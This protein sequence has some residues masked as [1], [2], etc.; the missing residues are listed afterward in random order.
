MSAAEVHDPSRTASLGKRHLPALF[1]PVLALVVLASAVGRVPEALFNADALFAPA[2]YRDLFL[3]GG[4]I[5]A[6][7]FPPPGFLFPDLFFYFALRALVGDFAVAVRLY[8][9]LQTLALYAGLLYFAHA[10]G[11]AIGMS[12][13]GSARKARL[14]GTALAMLV[15]LVLMFQ[16]GG[17]A[18]YLPLQ[19]THHTGAVVL[20]LFAAGSLFRERW[21]ALGAIVC[22]GMLSD[23]LFA[24]FF[25]VPAAL[26]IVFDPDRSKRNRRLLGLLA[27]AALGA[28]LFG[29]LRSYSGL[30]LPDVPLTL[31]NLTNADQFLTLVLRGILDL[32]SIQS[33]F[34]LLV[35]FLCATG[36]AL[37]F[38]ARPPQLGR[39]ARVFMLGTCLVPVLLS[40]VAALVQ[41]QAEPAVRYMLPALVWP[42]VAVGQFLAREALIRFA[43]WVLVFLV[44][45]SQVAG[46]SF[47]KLAPQQAESLAL[48]LEDRAPELR[49]GLAAYALAK[50]VDLF[51]RGHGGPFRINQIDGGG[52]PR[53]W[54]NS[55]AWYGGGSQPTPQYDFIL[56]AGLP[57]AKLR[58]RFGSPAR[59][60]VCPLSPVWIYDRPLARPAPGEIR[61]WRELIGR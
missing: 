48:C 20:S 6:W 2:L 59:V 9:L 31:E 33:V 35:P 42:F 25:V 49:D 41:N 16:G 32:F 22:L 51:R 18:F 45:I 47:F 26:A 12:P 27:P 61:L 34:P 43:S 7:S 53:Y 24:G 44:A 39:A 10:A 57:E 17:A 13:T 36:W 38:F 29:I 3:D 30:L 46:R 21:P 1:A 55:A 5:F 23:P 15:L 4:D 14:S 52:Q 54:L 19:L 60:L 56:P 58:E 37:L 28:L 40:L 11:P 50:P 8:G